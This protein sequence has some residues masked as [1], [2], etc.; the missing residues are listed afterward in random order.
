[1]NI[2]VFWD[3]GNGREE[4]QREKEFC[5][6]I[7]TIVSRVIEGLIVCLKLKKRQI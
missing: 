5:Y 2:P 7:L 1:V 3:A 4:N 6:A